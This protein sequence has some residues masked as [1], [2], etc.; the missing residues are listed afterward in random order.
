MSQEDQD[1]PGKLAEAFLACRSLLA[2]S[3]GRVVKPHD[4]EDI[5]QETFIRCF[6]AASQ[7]TIRHPQSFMLR[8]ARN[9]ALNHV[10]RAEH[11]LTDQVGDFSALDVYSSRDS[12][13]ANVGARQKFLLF[14]RAVR[15]LPLQ[16]RRAFLLKK[17]YG[18]SQREIAVFLGLSESTVEKHISKGLLMCSEYLAKAQNR[19]DRIQEEAKTGK[20]GIVD[21]QLDAVS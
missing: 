8:T 11:R 13:E 5:V 19:A 16:C 21:E 4:I 1:E 2:R 7:R 14:C 17:V 10:T 15:T 3:V 18:F 6:E 12:V 9:L 20:S